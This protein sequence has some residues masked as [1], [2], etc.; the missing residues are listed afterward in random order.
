MW[1]AEN[2]NFDEIDSICQSILN[3]EDKING[4]R[5]EITQLVQKEKEKIEHWAISRKK[6]MTHNV[7]NMEPY[8]DI[9]LPVENGAK[10]EQ[11]DAVTQ[12]A[13]DEMSHVQES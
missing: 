8:I 3:K 13:V 10:P 1:A 2:I 9:E 12:P 7:E 4:I 11:D 5:M 6:S